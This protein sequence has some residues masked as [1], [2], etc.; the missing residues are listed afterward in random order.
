GPREETLGENVT[1]RLAARVKA[2]GSAVALA[3][4]LPES[5]MS[6]FYHAVNVLALPSVNRTE[7]FGLVQVEALRCG[8][9]VVASDLP[10]VRTVVSAT[11]AGR[12]VPPG[13]AAA[14]TEA[15]A[16]VL[17]E[18]ARFRPDPELV[19]RH[20]E[21]GRIAEEWIALYRALL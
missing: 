14:L 6:D 5:R 18:P 15:L 3:G 21:A 8:V 4:T 13:D 1:R 11:G 12:L 19:A 9:P 17:S 10:G 16:E 7:S 20:Y 2:L